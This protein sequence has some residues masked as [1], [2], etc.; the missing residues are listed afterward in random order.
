LFALAAF[1]GPHILVLDEPTNHLDVDARQA[2]VQALNDYRGAVILISHDRHLIETTADHLW[3]ADGGTV[4]AYDGDLDSYSQHVLD[5][6]RNRRRSGG[7]AQGNGASAPPQ[8]SKRATRIDAAPLHRTVVESEAAIGSLQHK[9]LVLDQALAD[10]H[11]YREEPDKVAKFARL[12]S[13]LAAE[14]ESAEETW[15]KAQSRLEK[16]SQDA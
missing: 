6:A 7:D 10:P 13:R 16:L 14:L 12:R 1:R 15:L 3:I 4:K 9:I 2:L 8:K 5:C 11:L